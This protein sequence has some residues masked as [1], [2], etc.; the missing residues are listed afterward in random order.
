MRA[1]SA[2]EEAPAA[3]EAPDER[4]PVPSSEILVDP[5]VSRAKFE[6][7]LTGYAAIAADRRRLGWWLLSAEFPEILVAFAT[8]QLRPPAVAFGALL[9]FTNYDLWPPSV[10]LVSPFTGVPYRVKELPPALM[11]KRRLPN[12]QQVDLPGVGVTE[13]YSEQAL[14]VAHGPDEVPFL[15]L[16]GVREYHDHPAHTG[17]DWLLHRNRG[18]GTLYFILDKLYRYGVEPLK[19]F[20]YRIQIQIA[21]FLRPESPE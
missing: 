14:L 7:E 6:R 5:A 19:G 16:P 1:P 17:D 10:K 11:F 4:A 13:I 8:P 15:C 9:D 20:E 3:V 18:E 2:Q 21:D 12:P